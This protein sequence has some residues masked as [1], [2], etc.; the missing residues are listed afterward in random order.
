LALTANQSSSL[1][2]LRKRE[3]PG[4]WSFSPRTTQLIDT[5]GF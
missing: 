2:N 3:R 1:E 4:A 5:P